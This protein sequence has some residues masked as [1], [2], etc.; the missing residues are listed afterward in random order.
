MS[1][2]DTNVKCLVY[3]LKYKMPLGLYGHLKIACKG[4]L[5]M[6]LNDYIAPMCIIYLNLKI[7]IWWFMNVTSIAE[8]NIYDRYMYIQSPCES[9]NK[10]F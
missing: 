7:T 2:S 4:S 3:S 5:E 9:S 8:K 10:A 1:E 6:Y